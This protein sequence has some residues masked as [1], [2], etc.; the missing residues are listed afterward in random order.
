MQFGFTNE[1]RDAAGSYTAQVYKEPWAP[2]DTGLW[3]HFAIVRNENNELEMKVDGE[4]LGTPIPI[5]GKLL[6]GQS[7]FQVGGYFGEKNFEGK[8]DNIRV[9]R[10]RSQWVV[11]Y[12]YRYEFNNPRGIILVDDYLY[13][14]DSGHGRI[15]KLSKDFKEWSTFGEFG[16]DEFQFNKPTDIYHY[17]GEFYI[18]DT[19][20]GRVIKTDMSEMVEQLKGDSGGSWE[21]VYSS[22]SPGLWAVMVDD[23]NILISDEYNAQIIKNGEVVGNKNPWDMLFRFTSPVDIQPGPEGHYYILDGTSNYDF[24]SHVGSRAMDMY[25]TSQKEGINTRFST[26][27]SIVDFIRS[28][29]VIARLNLPDWERWIGDEMGHGVAHCPEGPLAENEHVDLGACP[30]GGEWTGLGQEVDCTDRNN[31]PPSECVGQWDWKYHWPYCVR[32]VAAYDS[33]EVCNEP[34]LCLAGSITPVERGTVPTSGYYVCGCYDTD[35]DCFSY[36]QAE[37]LDCHEGY[38][39][40]HEFVEV[41]PPSYAPGA[42]EACSD[43]Y[44]SNAY[45]WKPEGQNTGKLVILLPSSFPGNCKVTVDGETKSSTGRANGCRTHYRFSKPGGSYTGSVEVDCSGYITSL[46]SGGSDREEYGAPYGGPDP[47]EPNPPAPGEAEPD[48]FDC[49]DGAVVRTPGVADDT[50][51]STNGS[52]GPGTKAFLW[53]PVSDTTGNLVILLPSTYSSRCDVTISSSVGTFTTGISHSGRGNGNRPHYRFSHSGSYYGSNISV[54]ADCPGED[55]HWTVSNGGSRS[56][57]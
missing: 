24:S 45:L 46:T 29:E 22:A 44:T 9:A 38:A 17:E 51:S 7:I 40:T 10:G 6:D 35:R 20:N 42:S 28:Q 14:V 34:K 31:A 30:G 52:P 55:G 1:D 3:Y 8:M 4:T 37:E 16:S 5:T 36:C 15:V 13:I 41:G 21:E 11:D 32:Y 53:K 57:G 50:D 56:G 25:G 12:S 23:E 26:G 18:T 39:V 43:G 19:G 47:W 27:G 33:V 48:N 54:T 49:L 2:S